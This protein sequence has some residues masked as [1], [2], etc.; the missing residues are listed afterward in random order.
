MAIARPTTTFSDEFFINDGIYVSFQL[1]NG[2]TNIINGR[3]VTNIT[4]GGQSWNQIEVRHQLSQ[5]KLVQFLSGKGTPG[6]VTI[7]FYYSPDD[8]PINPIDW[9]NSF[10]SAGQGTLYLAYLSQ[11]SGSG[12]AVT[13][14]FESQ[15]NIA[16]ANS[17]S[18]GEGE[19][20][21]SSVKFQLSGDPA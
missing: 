13:V 12:T 14:F 5:E 11:S 10:K 8:E 1:A 16:E 7:E 4:R 3:K 2:G 6:D 19:P 20:F 18:G 21:K 9:R 15:A 17:L